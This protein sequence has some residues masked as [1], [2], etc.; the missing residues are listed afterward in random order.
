[1]KTIIAPVDFSAISENAALYA[2]KMAVATEAE[3]YLVHMITMPL[4]MSEATLTQ[5]QYDAMIETAENDMRVLKEKL[6]E[7]TFGALQVTSA[8]LTS[9]VEEALEALCSEK[10][11]FAIIMGKER[12]NNVERVLIGN[13]TIDAA[14]NLHCP[15]WAIPAGVSFQPFSKL[16]FACDFKDIDAIPKNEIRA[17]LNAFNASLCIVHVCKNEKEVIKSNT[18]SA[19][20]REAMNEFWPFIYTVINDSVEAGVEAFA[21]QH[22]MGPII[23]VPKKKGV[24][25]KLFRKSHSKPLIIKAHRPVIA[26]TG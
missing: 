20:V 11:P 13:H 14:R 15:V 5:Y 24:F 21:E 3:L 26:I 7:Q 22:N 10:K 1:M 25:D 8:V 9:N 17:V 2:A 6:H 16:V 12:E 18:A 23:I 19:Q 4:S